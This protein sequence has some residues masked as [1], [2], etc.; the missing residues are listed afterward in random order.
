MVSQDDCHAAVMSIH[1]VG[2]GGG[3][4]AAVVASSS[5]LVSYDAYQVVVV[6]VRT[7]MFL[8]C[9]GRREEKK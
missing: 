5:V 1:T 9:E 2:G 7:V 8:F 3:V 4:A 6:A